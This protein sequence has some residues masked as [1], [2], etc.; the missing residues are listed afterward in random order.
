[1]N[2]VDADFLGGSAIGVRYLSPTELLRE[3]D[4]VTL[5]C[6]LL[7]DTYHLIDEEAL[8]LVKPGAML[9]NTSRGTLVATRAIIAALKSGR[10]GYLG[11]DVYEEEA[12][13][14]FRD[15]SLDVDGRR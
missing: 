13:V 14:F 10:L 11:L 12:D 15:L 6:P 8:E 4:L 1:M 9:I 5:H 2:H 3:S 7:P